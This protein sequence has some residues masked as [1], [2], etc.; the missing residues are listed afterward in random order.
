MGS[1]R[2]RTPLKVDPMMSGMTAHLRARMKSSPG[3]PMM[4]LGPAGSGPSFAD[5]AGSGE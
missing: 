3:R 2:L 1:A 5:C 4:A